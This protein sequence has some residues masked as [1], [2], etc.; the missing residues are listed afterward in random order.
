MGGSSISMFVGI[1]SLPLGHQQRRLEGITLHTRSMS[2]DFLACSCRA[3][4]RKRS[5]SASALLL[6]LWLKAMD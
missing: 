2:E 3:R 4:P 6:W 5:Y 1:V